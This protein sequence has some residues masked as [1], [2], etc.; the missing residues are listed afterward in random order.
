[1]KKEVEFHIT[2]AEG[3]KEVLSSLPALGGKYIFLMGVGRAGVQMNGQAGTSQNKI[4]RM[5]AFIYI[6]IY[7]LGGG[8]GVVI[9]YTRGCFI[10]S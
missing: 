7:N 8:G 5:Y 4:L 3:H 1:M 6:Y 9:Y 10:S 2:P